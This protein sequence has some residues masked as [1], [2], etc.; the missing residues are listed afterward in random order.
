[1]SGWTEQD[2]RY[3][4]KALQLAKGGLYSTD[5]NPR[6][7]CVLTRHGEVV[8]SG[9]HVRAGEP[10]AE[11][12]ALQQAGEQARGATAYVTLEPCS[13][14]GRTP[15]CADA[16]ITA[17]VSKVVVAMQ[18]PNPQVAG[19]GLRRLSEAGVAVSVGLL[20]A[21]AQALNPGF[22][23]RMETGRPWVRV[24]LA[25]SLDGRTAMHSGQSQWITGEPA[26]RDVQRLR[27]RSSAI[28]T[29]IAT[30]LADDPALTVRQLD[31]S[32]GEVTPLRQ[33]LR[34]ILDSQGRLPEQANVLQ[35]PGRTLWVTRQPRLIR[36][37]DLLQAAL[38]EQGRVDL[39]WLLRHLATQEQC[40]EVL[41]EAG[42]E[43]AGALLAAD[44]VDELVVYMA[45]TLLG[46][47]ARPLLHLPLDEMSQQRRLQLT[48][49]RQLGDDL[50]LTYRPQVVD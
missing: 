49:L 20:A 37:A 27:A 45:P 25:M 32:P 26:R 6:V 23:R 8:G 18:D 42:A 43:L 41:V 21:Q 36:G 11:V 38:N 29:G 31:R 33:P 39:D 19:N 44:L 9:Y 40:N 2:Y 50:R 17:G 15:P 3:M 35:Q 14:Q 47:S 24:K 34:V 28:L 5:P 12:Y 10:H 46:S 16:L 48:D 30:V 1:M 22:V 4:A 13:H 7:G